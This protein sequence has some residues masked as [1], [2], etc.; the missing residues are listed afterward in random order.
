MDSMNVLFEYYRC[1]GGL[2]GMVPA[3][4]RPA[5]VCA[6]I[7]ESMLPF[8]AG[9]IIENLRRE[10]YAA[11][12]HKSGWLQ[13]ETLRRVYYLLRPLAPV[14]VRRQ[15]QKLH[16][17]GWE[18]LRFPAW[19]VD[20]TV[21]RVHK[22]LLALTLREKGLK[23]TP[24]IWFWP[25]GQ[26]SCAIMTHD[27]ETPFAE[28][29]CTRLMDIDD[30]AGIKSSFQF[31]PEGRCSLRPEVL[32]Q[33]RE[34]GFE[35]NIHDLNHDGHLFDNREEFLRRADR[36]NHFAR[37]YGAKGFRSAAL[38]R[39][40]EW[41]GGLEFSYDMSIPNVAHLDPQRGGC[42]TVMPYFIG[43][44]LELPVTTAQDYTLFHMLGEYNI[45]LWKRQ[46]GLIMEEN[47]LA[48]FI[49]HPDYLNS[50]RATATYA[51]LLGYLGELRA[52]GKIW[53]ALPGEVDTWWRERS[54]MQLV[55]EDGKW[56]IEGPGSERARIAYATVEGDTVGYR[57][58]PRSSG[59]ANKPRPPD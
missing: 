19:P 16:L 24:F 30:G 5:E 26:P 59:A 18:E 13:N 1:P 35:I 43:E 7:L 10:R 28:K 2:D 3:V 57:V 51:A 22:R 32:W 40:A 4:E 36:I 39:N 23:E 27:V 25:E 46:L 12:G 29:A 6:D 33:V 15:L 56:R 50:R 49:V 9:E 45:D 54:Q 8:D 52:A 20:R 47:G 37:F 38:Y 41:Y 55:S 53:M 34:R 11:A 42:C 31:V 14:A 48:S 58:A 44:L 21:E 17:R